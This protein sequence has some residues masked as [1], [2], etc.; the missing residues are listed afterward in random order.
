MNIWLGIYE[1]FENEQA[2]SLPQKDCT[3]LSNRTGEPRQRSN[4]RADNALGAKRHQKHRSKA[5]LAPVG[6]GLPIVIHHGVKIHNTKTLPYFYTKNRLRISIFILQFCFPCLKQVSYPYRKP[7]AI[8]DIVIVRGGFF[9]AGS[10][11]LFLPNDKYNMWRRIGSTLLL[12]F[13]EEWEYV[14]AVITVWQFY[15]KYLRK[16]SRFNLASSV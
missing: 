14:L 12:R 2:I 7:I 6:F 5:N 13:F 8:A 9:V 16:A 4:E 15:R 3:A 10:L 11:P 1:R